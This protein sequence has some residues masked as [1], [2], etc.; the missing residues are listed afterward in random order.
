MKVILIPYDY[1]GDLLTR[2]LDVFCAIHYDKMD[3][4]IKSITEKVGNDP[5]PMMIYDEIYKD[6]KKS[7][8]EEP[9]LEYVSDLSLNDVM[10][11]WDD[12]EVNYD[13]RSTPTFGPLKYKDFYSEIDV[14]NKPFFIS[15][16]YKVKI[17]VLE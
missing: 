2:T 3:M 15:Y 11:I 6:F 14:T 5:I 9:P 8:G 17:H 10:F 16:Q 4:E 1:N 12:I 13:Y 7:R